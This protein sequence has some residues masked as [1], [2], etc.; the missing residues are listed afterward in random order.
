MTDLNEGEM[1]TNAPDGYCSTGPKGD[2][3]DHE[4]DPSKKQCQ[5]CYC[6]AMDASADSALEAQDVPGI[7]RSDV[8]HIQL[9]IHSRPPEILVTVFYYEQAHTI[10][11]DII[12]CMVLCID[13]ETKNTKW[14]T[15]CKEAHEFYYGEEG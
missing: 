13:P 10:F 7:W 12:Q 4:N 14:V 1:A 2:E 3:C 6:E 9:G 5:E 15:N 11:S 8:G